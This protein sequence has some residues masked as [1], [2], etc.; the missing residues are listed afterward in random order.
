MVNYTDTPYAREA[1]IRKAIRIEA[2]LRMGGYDTKNARWL[3]AE[4]RRAVEKAAGVRPASEATWRAVFALLD[5]I[6]R[7]EGE[8]P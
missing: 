2:T 7:P 1:R 3:D 8:S 5:A 4:S 6:P